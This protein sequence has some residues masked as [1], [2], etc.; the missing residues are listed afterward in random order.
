[1]LKVMDPNVHQLSLSRN[2]PNLDNSDDDV[3]H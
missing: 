3:D 1:M 2:K